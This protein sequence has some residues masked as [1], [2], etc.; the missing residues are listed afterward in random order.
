MYSGFGGQVDFIRGAAEG[1]D[2]KGKPIIAI[3]SVTKRNESK[4]VPTLKTGTRIYF[5]LFKL[6]TWQLTTFLFRC[7]CCNITSPRSLCRHRAWYRIFV[8]QIDSTTGP[9]AHSNSTS[10]PPWSLGKGCLRKTQVHAICLDQMKS[11]FSPPPGNSM[12]DK[13]VG[14]NHAFSKH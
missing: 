3:P 7:W 13:P 6:M 14:I 2:G 4:I 1:F 11:C 8:R 12:N 10:R 5:L 9:C